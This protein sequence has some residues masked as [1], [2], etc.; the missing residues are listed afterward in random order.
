MIV[1]IEGV[2]GSGKTTLATALAGM[3]S[4]GHARTLDPARHTVFGDTLRTAIMAA[5]G[6]TA[7]A[8][9][10]AFA[11]A[12][13]HTAGILA[14]DRC[15]P[16]SDLVVLERWAGAVAAYGA[17][18]GGSPFLLRALEGTLTGALPIDVTVLVDV[19]GDIAADRLRRL[20]DRNRFETQGPAYLERV[21]R[22]YLAWAALRQVP[23]INGQQKAASVREQVAELIQARAAVT[24]G[25]PHTNT[26]ES[27]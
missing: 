17:V 15:P 12:R 10:L 1:C 6:L 23:V 7:D 14:A 19:P 11:S 16:A 4:H 26:Q 18:A 21:R 25:V 2:N 9:T 13:L 8:E 22:Q 27:A 3:W 5:T 20:G 24:R